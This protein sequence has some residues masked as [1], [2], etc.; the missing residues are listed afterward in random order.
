[1]LEVRNE[2]D[3]FTVYDAADGEPVMRFPTRR[4]ADCF[5]AELAI[6]DMHAQLQRWSA[7]HVPAIW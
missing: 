6:A 4:A 2:Q 7:D 5:I 3:D 1:M